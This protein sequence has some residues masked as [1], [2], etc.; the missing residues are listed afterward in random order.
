MPTSPM[1]RRS[2]LLLGGATLTRMLTKSPT[3]TS[4][5]QIL[6]HMRGLEEL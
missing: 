1:Y 4:I 5:N 2:F 3:G 6:G